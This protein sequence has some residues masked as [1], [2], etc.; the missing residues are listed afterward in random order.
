MF[1]IRTRRV[2][3]RPPTAPTWA[4][5]PARPP[6]T[7][8]RLDPWTGEITSAGRHE[9]QFLPV[10]P[11]NCYRASLTLGLGVRSC[12]TS[13]GC[14]CYTLVHSHLTN[15][16]LWIYFCSACDGWEKH[17]TEFHSLITFR[18]ISERGQISSSI[19]F[20][21]CLFRKLRGEYNTRTYSLGKLAFQTNWS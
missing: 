4:A 10:L 9:V 7:R 16:L 17:T 15:L 11:L 8:A 6:Q 13:G 5:H 12:E 1:R 18:P 21:P 20:Y 14:Y 2:T 3:P 19:L